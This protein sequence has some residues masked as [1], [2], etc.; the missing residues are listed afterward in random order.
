MSAA[1]RA[2]TMIPVERGVNVKRAVLFHE[3]MDLVQFHY[4]SSLRAVH[5]EVKDVRDAAIERLFRAYAMVKVLDIQDSRWRRSIG[6]GVHCR[7]VERRTELALYREIR[8]FAPELVCKSTSIELYTEYE[9]DTQP[10]PYDCDDTFGLLRRKYHKYIQF[11][12]GE[13]FSLQLYHARVLLKACKIVGTKA[14]IRAARIVAIHLI[15]EVS[16]KLEP[17]NPHCKFDDADPEWTKH[18]V[19]EQYHSDMHARLRH[20]PSLLES[21]RGESPNVRHLEAYRRAEFVQREFNKCYDICNRHYPYDGMYTD[22][23]LIELA[24]LVVTTI[25]S[26][27]PELVVVKLGVHPHHAMD[28]WPIIQGLIEATAWAK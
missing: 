25:K 27:A 14:Q 9:L 21:I 3:V 23:E 5:A 10:W 19:Y 17:D 6:S 12:K 24:W 8:G 4:S 28:P 18:V 15:M 11:K 20:T 16:P 7:P 26:F 13:S 2:R 1:K 22:E